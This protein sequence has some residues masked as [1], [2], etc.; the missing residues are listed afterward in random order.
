MLDSSM[1]VFTLFTYDASASFVCNTHTNDACFDAFASFVYM[2]YT[3][4]A[5]CESVSFRCFCE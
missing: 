3:I 4:D 2:M 5:R 1:S